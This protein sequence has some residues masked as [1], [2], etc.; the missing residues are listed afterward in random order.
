[1]VNVNKLKSV[2]V[3]RGY[4]TAEVSTGANI[5]IGTLYRRYNKPDEF[6]IGEATA[7]VEFLKLSADEATA[8]F[9]NSNVA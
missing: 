6:T 3:E 1:M 2:I 5:K 8:I 4:S 7:L 9:F